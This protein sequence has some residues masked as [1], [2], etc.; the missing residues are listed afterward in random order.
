[1]SATGKRY[2]LKQNWWV[3][4]RSDPEKATRAAAR[5]LKNLYGLLGDWNLAL[6]GYNAGE[7]KVLRGVS[8]YST[9]DF[10]VL[11]RTRAFRTETKNYVPL[12]HAAIVV[13]ALAADY[14]GIGGAMPRFGLRQI[15]GAIVGAVV[16]IAG[17]ILTL[18]K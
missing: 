17:L 8:R 5:Y 4:E 3:D 2:G 15:V 7:A 18:R 1:M 14:I 11:R 9:R 13:L 6:A 10:W 12:I 16:A